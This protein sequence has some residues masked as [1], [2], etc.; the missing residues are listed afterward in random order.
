MGVCFF[1]IPYHAGLLGRPVANLMTVQ[2]Y[3]LISRFPGQV[4]PKAKISSQFA[5]KSAP[6]VIRWENKQ[7]TL[8][9]MTQAKLCQKAR[10]TRPTA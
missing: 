3:L 2:I 6:V 5:N 9:V 4:L 1:R 7:L 8:Q 10:E